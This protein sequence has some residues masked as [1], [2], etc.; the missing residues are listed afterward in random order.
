MTKRTWKQDL[1]EFNG[2]E[3]VRLLG[4]PMRSSRKGPVIDLEPSILERRVARAIVGS[5][6]PIRG[7]E[8]RFLRNTIGLS[9]DKFGRG[10][11]LTSATIFYWEKAADDRLLPINAVAVRAFTAQEL[12]VEIPG[13][14]TALLGNPSPET[15]TLEISRTRKPYKPR[16]KKR[17]TE[18]GQH[19]VS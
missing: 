16:T 18:I 19:A 11:G 17:E 9:L 13:S 7:K 14:W 2:L 12:G 3:N 4:V 8:V 15:I 10:L 6:T 1:N 5:R